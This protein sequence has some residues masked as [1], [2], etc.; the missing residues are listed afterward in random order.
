[1]ALDAARLPV[2]IS[3]TRSPQVYFSRISSL[4]VS[5]FSF[6]TLCVKLPASASLIKVN[7]LDD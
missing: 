3:I 1:M 6:F 7:L 4:M 5:M 2:A